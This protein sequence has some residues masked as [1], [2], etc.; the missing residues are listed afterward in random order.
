MA[1]TEAR[2]VAVGEGG[3]EEGDGTGVVFSLVEL[4]FCCFF[5][6]PKEVVQATMS[7]NLR[8]CATAC[9]SNE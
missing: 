8:T 1:G 3:E 6:F 4:A 7:S 2:V 9:S 5:A